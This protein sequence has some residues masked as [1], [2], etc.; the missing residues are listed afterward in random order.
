[1]VGKQSHSKFYTSQ[2]MQMPEWLS[3]RKN[4]SE[5]PKMAEKNSDSPS[6]ESKELG[7]GIF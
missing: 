2:P 7:R 3:Q 1:M 4:R 5:G 6:E